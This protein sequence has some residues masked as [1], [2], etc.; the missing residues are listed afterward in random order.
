M[1]ANVPSCLGNP[2]ASRTQESRHHPSSM[3]QST[4]QVPC[5]RCRHALALRAAALPSSALAL[6]GLS[7]FRMSYASSPSA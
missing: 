6:A 7:L 5:P 3:L 1:R 2:E 4:R